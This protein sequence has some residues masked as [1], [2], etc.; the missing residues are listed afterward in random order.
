MRR[1]TLVAAAIFCIATTAVAQSNYTPIQNF[2]EVTGTSEIVLTPDTFYVV[3]TIDEGDS[4]GRITAPEQQKRMIDELQ[5]IGVDIESQLKVNSLSSAYAQRKEAFSTISYTLKLTS[6][7]MLASTFEIVDKLYISN[8][9][10]ER[11]ESS[12]YS[13]A[14]SEARRAAAQDAQ[15]AA[16]ELAKEMKV[17]LG[18]C[19]YIGDMSNDYNPS[20]YI[21]R[22]TILRSNAADAAASISSTPLELKEIK[23][24]YK[25]K[26]KFLIEWGDL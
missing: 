17:E 4:K 24:N 20:N 18:S 2:I 26:T 11:T 7:E 21:S 14:K 19:F 6:E 25:V 1:L 9:Y 8:V 10:L 16:K 5:K 3:I 12:K 15:N 13:E 23:I 22:P